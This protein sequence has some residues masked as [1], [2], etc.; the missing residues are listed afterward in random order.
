MTNEH[1]IRVTLT[2]PPDPARYAT[3]VLGV[4][5]LLSMAGLD[6]V[7]TVHQDQRVVT[8]EEL[9]RL[10]DEWAEASPWG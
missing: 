3:V 8:D 4:Q 6:Q 1:T 10:A 5:V 7:A 9:G 2:G